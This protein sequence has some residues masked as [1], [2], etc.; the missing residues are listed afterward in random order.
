MNNKSIS[1]TSMIYVLPLLLLPGLAL[2]QCVDEKPSRR[3]P[4]AYAYQN[5]GNYCEGIIVA[6]VTAPSLEVVGVIR[7]CL[8][9]VHE[10]SQNSKKNALDTNG[11]YSQKIIEHQG[12]QYSFGLTLS[13]G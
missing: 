9:A 12:S 1:L 5:F 7:G 11:F 13:I 8:N 10:L 6:E 3:V 4:S 2:S